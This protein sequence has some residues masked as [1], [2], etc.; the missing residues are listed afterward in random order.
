MLITAIYAKMYRLTIEDLEIIDT[1][2]L[3]SA[4]VEGVEQVITLAYELFWLFSHV[5]AGVWASYTFIGPA[6]FFIFL[7]RIGKREPIF[8]SNYII[9]PA[10]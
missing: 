6:A 2:S 4:D 9:Q 7:P 5:L 1:A 8:F 3:I 10:N